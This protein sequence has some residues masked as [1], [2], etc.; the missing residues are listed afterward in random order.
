MSMA[1]CS[2]VTKNGIN[3][4]DKHKSYR[5][6]KY[7]K[8]GKQISYEFED[9]VILYC[10]NAYKLKSSSP[11]IDR[12][13]FTYSYSTIKKAAIIIYNKEY[14]D[15]RSFIQKWHNDVR[16]RKLKFTNKWVT[17]M[18]R[19]QSCI[20]SKT[21]TAAATA[22]D[23]AATAAA[24]TTKVDSAGSRSSSS[25]SR[26]SSTS[27]NFS[28]HNESIVTVVTNELD[29]YDD[30]LIYLLHNDDGYLYNL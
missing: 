19:R 4:A 5:E 8:P 23:F 16:T 22:P 17:G 20:S 11:I 28:I 26:S 6:T 2:K 1:R 25:S 7:I 29:L 24:A 10:E 14:W 21:T 12:N 30:Y 9:E 18:L 13:K 27:S 15:G 3:I